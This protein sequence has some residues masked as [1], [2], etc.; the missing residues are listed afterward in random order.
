MKQHIRSWSYEACKLEASRHDSKVQFKNAMPGAYKKAREKGWID[1]FF[2]VSIR[3]RLDYDTCKQLASHYQSIRDLHRSD[4]SL[5]KT[6]KKKGW[7]DDFFPSR[8]E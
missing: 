6:L 7:L 4:R 5:Y 2:P 8:T 1:E 3:R